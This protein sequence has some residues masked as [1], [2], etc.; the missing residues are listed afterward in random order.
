MIQGAMQCWK[1]QKGAEK[2]PQLILITLLI[3]ERGK[4]FGNQQKGNRRVGREGD[5]LLKKKRV[6]V[7]GPRVSRLDDY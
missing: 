6:G 5:I 4:N 2:R 3:S 7:L 1:R